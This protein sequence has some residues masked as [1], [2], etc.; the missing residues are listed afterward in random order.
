MKLLCVVSAAQR[1][2][3]CNP[4]LLPVREWLATTLREA[5]RDE[6]RAQRRILERMR[7]VSAPK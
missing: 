2:L 4:T 5:D 7:E 1:A 6:A 3:Q